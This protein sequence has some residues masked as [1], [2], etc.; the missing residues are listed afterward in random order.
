MFHPDNLG[1]IPATF[2]PTQEPTDVPTTYPTEEPSI[3]P[4]RP[5]SEPTSEPTEYPSV[6]PTLRPSQDPT[7][8]QQPSF[9]PTFE[10]LNFISPKLLHTY[11]FNDLFGEGGT[12][13]M[14]QLIDSTSGAY[15]VVPDNPLVEIVDGNAVFVNGDASLDNY[16][17][18]PHDFLGPSE[19]ITVEVWVRYEE[20][21]PSDSILFSFGD[22]VFTNSLLLTSPHSSLDV[23]IAVVYSMLTN[24]P[25]RK[26]YID[27]QLNMSV[28]DPTDVFYHP[29]NCYIGKSSDMTSPGM[30]AKI[31]EFR[32]WSGE[33]P[34][35]IIHSHY[36]TGVDPSHITLSSF[37]TITDINITYFATSTQLVNVGMYGGNS[38]IPMFGAET[39]FTLTAFEAMCDYSLTYTLDP[40]SSSYTQAIAAMNYTVTLSTSAKEA[41]VFSDCGNAPQCFCDSGKPPVT[42]M[43]ELGELSQDLRITEV[44]DS[45][46]SIAFTYHTGVCFEAKG[47]EHFSLSEGPCIDPAATILQKWQ[48]LTVNFVLFELYPEGNDWVQLFPN[49]VTALN[50]YRVD[51]GTVIVTDLVS[52]IKSPQR[53]SYTTQFI[54]V[55]PS[56][57]NSSTGM[58]YTISA[59]NPLPSSPFSWSFDVRV[60]RLDSTKNF[61]ISGPDTPVSSAIDIVWYIPVIGIISNEVPNFYP[62]ASDPTMIYLVLRD[63][64]GGSSSTTFHGGKSLS[65]DMSVDQLETFGHFASNTDGGGGGGKENEMNI[66]AP[67]GVGITETGVAA[68]DG[69]EGVSKHTQTITY[70]RGSDS[71]YTVTINFSYDISTS[72]DPRIAGHLSDV[73]VGGGVDLIVSEAIQGTL[74][75]SCN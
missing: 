67:L 71:H 34:E 66:E 45:L 3:S 65:F 75:I 44:R 50:D 63:P 18:L 38:Q 41:P 59:G 54:I 37:F 26:L 36:L 2:S 22:V 58:N 4:S 46:Y 30:V 16:L 12:P 39:E 24:P 57:V 23:Y 8:S 53:F 70:A 52:H 32:V 19:V 33:L 17:I 60:E 31:D 48:N 14:A 25:S 21:C 68:S 72:Q 10:I 28:S 29:E 7:W 11:K 5:T 49:P 1:C 56:L 73:I 40:H 69:V 9:Y 42:Y 6:E 20:S 62:V 51:N 74:H 15:A 47:S 55:P 43:T 35:H 13:A 61:A 64:P 27:G